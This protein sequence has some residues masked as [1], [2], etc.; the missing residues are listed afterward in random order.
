M[1]IE[2]L[3]TATQEV[4][5][6]WTRILDY[7]KL[8]EEEIEEYSNIEVTDSLREGGTTRRSRGDSGLNICQNGYGR[9]H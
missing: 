2:S 7:S 1:K 4:E 3:V 6:N 9:L 8:V 5:I